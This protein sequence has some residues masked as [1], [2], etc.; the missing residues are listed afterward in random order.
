MYVPAILRPHGLQV[1]GRR[2]SDVL[3]LDVALLHAQWEGARRRLHRAAIC[4]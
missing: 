3:V 1:K 4:K 2:R